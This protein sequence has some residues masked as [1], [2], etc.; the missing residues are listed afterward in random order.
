MA[1]YAFHPGWAA[2]RRSVHERISYPIQDRLSYG[3]DRS[4]QSHPKEASG[5]MWRAKSPSAII[6]DSAKP[7]E[8]GLGVKTVMVGTEV[9][10]LEEPIVSVDP[11]ISSDNMLAIPPGPM[12]NDHEASTSNVKPRDSKYTQPRWC[13][14]G[15]TK[16]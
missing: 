1:P 13:P 15:I 3:T 9:L 10:K 12:A 6:P 11:V 5:K 7:K 2:P 4:M 14:L 16:T 8:Y